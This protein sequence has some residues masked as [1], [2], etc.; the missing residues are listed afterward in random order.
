[1]D[2]SNKNVKAFLGAESTREA[3]EAL[4]KGRETAVALGDEIGVEARIPAPVGIDP[5]LCKA[6]GAGNELGAYI[7]LPGMPEPPE[8]SSLTFVDVSSR[9]VIWD[10]P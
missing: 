2:E 1:M 8:G 6:L 9:G 10:P 3:G 7:W 4:R 5:D